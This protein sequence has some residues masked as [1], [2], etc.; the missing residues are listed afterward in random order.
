MRVLIAVGFVFGHLPCEAQGE[1]TVYKYDNGNVSSEGYMVDGRPDGYWKTY[2][3]DGTLKS[4]GNR[5]DF[6]LDST[7][8]FYNETGEKVT[9]IT[10]RAGKKHGRYIAYRNGVLYEE[11]QFENEVKVGEALYYYPTGELNKR[12]PFEN[13]KEQGD[14]FEFDR[15]GRI[16]TLL[17]Y[18]EGFLRTADKV[19]RFDTQGKKRG[20]WVRFHPNG[21]LAYEGRFMNDM[22]N[23]IFKTYDKRG[24]LLTLEKYRDDE[25]VTDS[26]ESVILDIRNTYYDD[27]T[28]KSTGGYV[29]GVKEGT[30][31]LYDQE[32]NITAG[33]LYSKGEKIGEGIID[34]NGDYQGIWKLYF[35]SGELKAEGEFENSKRTGDWIYY[36]KNG[37]TEHKA[38]FADGL[39]NGRWTWYYED[40]KLRREEFFRRG[41]EDGTV[42]EYDREGNIVVQGDYISGLRDGTWF[43]NVGDHTE[44]GKYTDG[45][46]T[47]EWI[48]EYQD[49]SVA[50]EGEYVAGMAV[51]KHKWY[52]PNGQVKLEGKYKSG[53]RVGT[54]RKYKEDG[55]LTLNVK[56]KSGREVKIN[57]KRVIKA[58]NYVP[59]I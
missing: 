42:K 47:G 6:E 38:K 22:K 51:G 16:I 33:E 8:I 55:E 17:S 5:A 25:L 29:D 18:R 45:E 15:E 48:Y 35:E 53:L 10:Y 23:G 54:W 26:E 19:N 13:G 24:D 1:Y 31:R 37:E 27:G 44:R 52:H 21:V 34:R 49:E 36:H 50:Y 14:G 28:V 40:G 3:P 32:G 7:W 30:H 43:L 12:I 39:P 11:S 57:G 4:E 20:P 59:E 2:H 9:E 58:E 46:R 41:K 56:Y